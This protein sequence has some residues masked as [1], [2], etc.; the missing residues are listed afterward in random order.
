MIGSVFIVSCG[1]SGS[2][3]L[4][5][6]VGSHPQALAVGELRHLPKNIALDSMCSCGSRISACDF[7]RPL[8]DAAGHKLEADLWRDPYRLDLGYVMGAVEIDHARQTSW[9]RFRRSLG[10][11]WIEVALAAGID[12]RKSPLLTGFRRGLQQNLMVHD[13]LREQT[14]RRVVVD[15]TKG[16][17]WSV[18][19]YLIDP[20]R[21]RLLLLSRDG[22]GVMASMMRS[23]KSAAA[24]AQAWS[25]YYERALPWLERH[26]P[27]QHVL[28][29]RYEDLAGDTEATL[30]RIF[31]FLGLPPATPAQRA[32]SPEP[33]IVNGNPMRH[34]AI[35]RV[36][37]DE[38]WRRELTADHLATFQRY[39]AAV[40]ARLGYPLHQVDAA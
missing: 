18:G 16:F 29:V 24:A 40:S 12:V 34:E 26:V 21:S 38:R 23:G 11:Q 37:I 19:Q 30:A 14:R 4:D 7:W 28:R 10:L 31:A 2:T 6:L 9:Y 32:A 39:A 20:Q 25:K 17:R 1:R 22:R 3:L 36:S 8:I 13:L 33:H 15:S 27:P 5:R 35:V